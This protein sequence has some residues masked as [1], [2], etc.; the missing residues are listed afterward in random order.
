M[1]LAGARSSTVLCQLTFKVDRSSNSNVWQ[2]CPFSILK[3]DA[4]LF[5]CYLQVSPWLWFL[6]FLNP[7]PWKA[8]TSALVQVQ[9]QVTACS[10]C[11][12]CIVAYAPK[13]LNFPKP[14][15]QI[16][17][18]HNFLK[19]WRHKS[20][21]S[22]AFPYFSKTCTKMTNIVISDVHLTLNGPHDLSHG[23]MSDQN[24]TSKLH[25]TFLKQS[26][27]LCSLTLDILV[28]WLLGGAGTPTHF[29]LNYVFIVDNF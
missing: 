24:P 26:F 27:H 2:R 25:K 18:F 16:L 5:T 29:F 21:I 12:N 4:T 19:S 14:K 3:I 6:H 10:D 9:G 17:I 11:R 7:W 8:Y 23:L 13:F 1:H 15:R 22:K 28:E 20:Q